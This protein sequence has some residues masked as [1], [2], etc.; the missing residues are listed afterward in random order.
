MVRLTK[1]EKEILILI[2]DGLKDREI[3]TVLS[4]GERTSRTYV[5]SIYNKLGAV[6]RPNAIQRA[7]QLGVF[8]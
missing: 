6:N 8:K 3:A 2:A 7:W 1:R 5:I 4:M